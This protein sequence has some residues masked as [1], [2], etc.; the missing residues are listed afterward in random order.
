MK[1]ESTIAQNTVTLEEVAKR[2]RVSAST[3]SRVL[4]NLSVVKSST[5]TRVLKA[6]EELGYSPDLA[7]RAL[8]SRSRETPI[9]FCIP[10]ELRAFFSEIRA[11]AIYEAQRFATYGIRLVQSS[12]RFITDDITEHVE[13]L[14]NSGV[15]GIVLCPGEK[16]TSH[17]AI[18]RAERNGIR[19]VCCGGDLSQSERT[20]SVL[21]DPDALG[22]LAGELLAKL[23]PINSRVAVM[24]GSLS[25]DGHQRKAAAF[26]RTFETYCVGGE[27]VEIIQGNDDP[28]LAYQMLEALLEKDS[29]LSGIFVA[30]VNSLPAC[31]SLTRRGLAG[32]VRLITTDL[33]AEMKPFLENGTIS[34]SL[35]Q[36][37]FSLGQRAMRVLVDLI[38]FNTVPDKSYRFSPEIIMASNAFL[39]REMSIRGKH[40]ENQEQ[41]TSAISFQIGEV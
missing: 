28:V 34:A 32:K 15:K 14:I 3:V 24:T 41:T 9:G 6:I 20:S 2:A 8:A 35:Y 13:S 26:Q 10:Q 33:F 22:A 36:S 19:V 30:T 37:P 31:H 5:R 4:S 23:V 40:S 29:S 27:V 16:S 1:K 38:L 18:S 7:A 11:G 21:V 17:S 12:R 39:F 25:I